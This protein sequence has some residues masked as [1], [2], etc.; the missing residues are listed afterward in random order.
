[1]T[2]DEIREIV[3]KEIENHLS[4][5]VDFTSYDNDLKVGLYY[6]GKEISK[7]RFTIPIDN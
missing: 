7:D 2:K 3:R 5:E 4:V 6:G 1:M